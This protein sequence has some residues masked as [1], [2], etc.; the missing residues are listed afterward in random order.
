MLV[1]VWFHDYVIYMYELTLFLH[2]ECMVVCREVQVGVLLPFSWS[3]N[4][5]ANDQKI[6]RKLWKT[7]VWLNA[8]GPP[9]WTTEYWIWPILQF[10]PI[11]ISPSDFLVRWC[12]RIEV[13]EIYI[14][15]LH[16]YLWLPSAKILHLSTK[17][18]LSLKMALSKIQTGQVGSKAQAQE[19]F[20]G[21]ISTKEPGNC[22]HHV[23][24]LVVM[25]GW[26]KGM[27]SYPAHGLTWRMDL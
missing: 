14:I 6:T 2:N 18:H 27:K 4:A 5:K 10:E 19:K 13:G 9:K 3:S 26:V 16:R 24:H 25:V 23:G 15:T 17:L 22:R 7:N 8:I 21:W 20:L 12:Y 1:D 11:A